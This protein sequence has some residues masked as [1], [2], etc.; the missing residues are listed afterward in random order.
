M[1]TAESFDAVVEVG[2]KR[3]AFIA[4][5]FAPDDV[6]GTKVE[7]HVAGTVGG[8]GV[9][10]VVEPFGDAWGIRLGPA[11]LR[12]RDVSVGDHVTVTLSPEG[13]QREDLPEDFR[14][15]LDARPEA[16]Q[17]F[18]SMAQFYRNAYVRW[19]EATK[20]R[21]DVRAER[22]GEVVDLLAAKVKERPNP[23]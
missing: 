8:C 21:P 18:D 1:T 23:A 17:F 4:L 6:W 10:A 5:P 9:R 3:R 7:H 2:P 14:A 22:I 16:G 19:I 11:W 20:R 15:A 12:D 13:V